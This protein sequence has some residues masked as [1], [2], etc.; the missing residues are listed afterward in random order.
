MLQST[1]LKLKS[2]TKDDAENSNVVNNEIQASCV[3]QAV[4]LP[5][6]HGSDRQCVSF[7]H[8]FDHFIQDIDIPDFVSAHKMELNFPLTV[9]ALRTTTES[10]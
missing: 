7:L 8:Q 1:P 5:R 4:K 10:A 2:R 9:S 3:S 6:K